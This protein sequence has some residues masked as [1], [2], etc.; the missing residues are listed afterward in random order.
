MKILWNSTEEKKNRQLLLTVVIIAF[1]FIW[2]LDYPGFKGIQGSTNQTVIL[3]EENESLTPKVV[4]NDFTT[5]AID[6]SALWNRTYGGFGQDR[7]YDI[8]KCSKGGFAMVG[9]TSSFT[10]GDSDIWVIRTDEHG[11]VIWTTTIGTAAEEESGNAIIECANGDFLIAGQ[12]QAGIYTNAR[13]DRITADGEEVWTYQ[14][15][16]SLEY[17]YF[18]DVIET[19]DENILVIGNTASYGSGAQDVLAVCLDKNGNGIWARTYGGVN[20]DLGESVIECTDGGYAILASTYSKGAGD[21]DFWLIRIDESG[22]LSWEWTYGG[23]NTERGAQIISYYDR[24]FVMVGS[25]ESLGDPLGDMWVVRVSQYGGVVWDKNFD[26]GGQDFATGIVLSEKGGFAVVGIID[27]L[28]GT[29]QIRVTRLDP[30]GNETWNHYYGGAIV[31]YGYSIVESRGDEFVVAGMT[32]SY[33]AGAFDA[34]LLLIPGPPDFK[35]N[36]DYLYCEYGDYPLVELFVESTA[37]I[38]SWW[39]TDTSHFNI[40]EGF[41]NYATIYTTRLLEVDIY[42]LNVHVNNTVGYEIDCWIYIDVYDGISPHWTE[43]P[44]NQ[45]IEYGDDFQYQL[46]ADDLSGIDHW[47]IDSSEEFEISLSG[48]ISS[49]EGLQVGEY[50][51]EVSVFDIYSH[52]TSCYL[53]VTVVDTTGPEWVEE[54][55]DQIIVYGNNFVYDLNATDLSGV[56]WSVDDT[57]R[58]TVDWQGRIR[59]LVPLAVGEHGVSVHVIDPY[60]NTLDG[61]FTITVTSSTTITGTTTLDVLGLAIPFIVGVVATVAVAVVVYLVGRRHT[62]SK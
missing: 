13:L 21:F 12:T 57:S 54:P 43:A 56:T 32:N 14:I 29:D 38:D 9:Y 16:D 46:A 37:E 19:G 62:P 2:I 15:G 49:T 5:S 50:H 35:Y 20:D 3:F 22:T 52:S 8:V 31:D 53:T 24:G 33:G 42:D 58:F 26:D 44:N 41:G 61:T 55:E 17:D 7:L 28:S 40:T 39:L 48:M 18:F 11:D 36:P 4:R 60:G 51:F 6:H 10:A 34:W 45:T 1:Y 27:Y 47:T 30:S 23:V 25:T 59:N